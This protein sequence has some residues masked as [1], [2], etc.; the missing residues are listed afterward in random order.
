MNIILKFI[1]FIIDLVFIESFKNK[2]QKI[3]KEIEKYKDKGEL[4]PLF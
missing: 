1:N 2:M 3:E 4:P